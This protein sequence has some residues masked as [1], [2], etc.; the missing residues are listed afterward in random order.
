M[1]YECI[2]IKIPAEFITV[3]DERT[4]WVDIETVKAPVDPPIKVKNEFCRKRWEPVMIGVGYRFEGDWW[5][6][7]TFNW[8]DWPKFFEMYILDSDTM[9]YRATRKFDEMILKGRFWNARRAFFEDKPEGWPGINEEAFEFVNIYNKMD[10]PPPRGEDIPSKDIPKV[11]PRRFNDMLVHLFRDVVELIMMD[12]LVTVIEAEELG[13]LMLDKDRCLEYI[14][15][16]E[17]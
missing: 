11:W 13:F 10:E 5:V 16:N 3:R 9:V 2:K 15:E 12:P 14:A 6:D 17:F 4:S 1:E 8:A 7:I